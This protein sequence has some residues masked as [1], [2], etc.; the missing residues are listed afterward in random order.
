MR[1]ADEEV[2]GNVNQE[3]SRIDDDNDE[4]ANMSVDHGPVILSGLSH[5]CWTAPKHLLI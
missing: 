1:G 3:L 2:S 4:D 5:L